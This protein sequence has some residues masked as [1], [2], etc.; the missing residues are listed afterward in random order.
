MEDCDG[1][2]SHLLLCVSVSLQITSKQ[3]YSLRSKLLVIEIDVSRT[4]IHLDTSI[5]ATVKLVEAYA[6]AGTRCVLF[7]ERWYK[8]GSS[9]CWWIDPQAKIYT[10]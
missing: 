6:F 7:I 3:I 8:G 4:K 5:P 10:R 2:D 1:L 9:G